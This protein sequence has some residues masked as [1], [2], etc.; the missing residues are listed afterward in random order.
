MKK[1]KVEVQNTL[2]YMPFENI[3][4]LLK[5]QPKKKSDKEEKPHGN[6]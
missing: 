5:E 6:V 2:T 3:K 1:R 4:E